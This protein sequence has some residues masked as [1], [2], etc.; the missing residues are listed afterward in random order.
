LN[1]VTGVKVV[2]FTTPVNEGKIKDF[3]TTITQRSPIGDAGGRDI[4]YTDGV[5]IGTWLYVQALLKRL[6]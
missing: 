5:E 4:S 3:Y 6:P 1:G 2:G